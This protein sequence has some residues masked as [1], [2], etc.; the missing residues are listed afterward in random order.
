MG[1]P[2]GGSERR[3]A[4]AAVAGAHGVRGELRLKLFTD[5]AENLRGHKTLLVGGTPR[6]LIDVRD[7]GK[8]AV[9]RFEGVSD[10]SAAEAL[11]GSLVEIE[12]EALP[13]LN[14][15]EYYHSDLIGLPCFDLEGASVGTVVEVENFGAGDLLEVELAE[16][17]RSLI[18]FRGGIADLADGKIVLDPDFLA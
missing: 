2:A 17:R 14:E 16:G 11:R 8:T 3:V 10:R 4:L 12:R 9:A 18:P 1:S 13:A 7:G 5:A 6:R 15:G